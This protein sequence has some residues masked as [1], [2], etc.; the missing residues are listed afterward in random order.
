MQKGEGGAY[1][2]RRIEGGAWVV[3]Q[4]GQ[5]MDLMQAIEERHSVRSYS[6]K[7]I[8]N[9]AA[10]RLERVIRR[11]NAEADLH[12]QLCLESPEAFASRLANYGMFD[13]VRNYVALVGRK[14][15]KL[16][17]NVGFYGELVAL[18]AQMAG[19]NT[20]WVAMTYRK[21]AL[22]AHV[23]E[24][25]A[26]P[27]VLAVGYGRN[28]GSAHKAKPVEKLFRSDVDP[29]PDWFMAAMGAARLAPTAMNQQR[30]LITLQDGIVRAEA[31]F[32]PCSRIDLGIVKRHFE[33]GA[34]STRPDWSWEKNET[35]G[36][37]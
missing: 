27:C 19:L 3:S 22:A 30:F 25:E 35:N 36:G 23:G 12:F 29:A 8:E 15:R 5:T 7:P 28:Q 16:E 33:I 34:Q 2:A 4:K 32:G 9:D 26:C 6:D 20:C 11:C 1:A 37:A 31:L 13:G 24:D 14:G 10:E 18:E 21:R 17:E